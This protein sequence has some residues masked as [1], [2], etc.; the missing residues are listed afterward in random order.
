MNG[1]IY[2]AAG[3]SPNLIPSTNY[4]WLYLRRLFSSQPNLHHNRLLLTDSP[5]A[6]S[7]PT[8]TSALSISCDRHIPLLSSSSNGVPASAQS[9]QP[10]I[11][12]S[13]AAPVLIEQFGPVVTAL[14]TELSL[15]PVLLYPSVRYL[16]TLGQISIPV[17]GKTRIAASGGSA[18]IAW[19]VLLAVSIVLQL[20]ALVVRTVPKSSATTRYTA[21]NGSKPPL[22]PCEFD[23]R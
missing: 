8:T 13:P 18:F 15:V 3:I 5:P 1:S 10:T 22:P 19:A 4:L 14:M 2:R 21:L 6:T 12:H 17:A 20:L 7:S 11:R 9:L 16:S 23:V